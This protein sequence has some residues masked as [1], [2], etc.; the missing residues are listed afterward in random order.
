MG[1]HPSLPIA[2]ESPA[3][4]CSEDDKVYIQKDPLTYGKVR[5]TTEFGTQ[6]F[7]WMEP[8]AALEMAYAIIQ[9]V[10]DEKFKKE[11]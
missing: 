10:F 4:G 3:G 9:I 5:I 1:T 6:N 2:W 11:D 8:E 7:T